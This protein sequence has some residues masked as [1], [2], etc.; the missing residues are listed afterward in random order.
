MLTM[1]QAVMHGRQTG[2]NDFIRQ[3]GHARTDI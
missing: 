2:K 3:T 1:E